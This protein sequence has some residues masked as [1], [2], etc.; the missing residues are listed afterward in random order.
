MNR[1]FQFV[2]VSASTCMLV[3]LL[4]G[5]FLG[6]SRAA[7]D[8]YRQFGVYTEVL[9]KIKSE[10][11]EEPDIKNVTLGAMMG[12][13]ESL[14]PYASYLNADQYK[15]YLRSRENRKGDVGL[16][17]ARRFGYVA[18]VASIPGSPAANAG[19]GTGDLLETIA[20][21]ATRDM[22]LAYADMLL[23]GEPGTKVDISVLRVRRGAE[24]QKMTLVREPVQYPA[25]T[26]QII[27]GDVAYLAVPSLGPGRVG[28]V[29][30]HLR[31][32]TSRGA[33]RIVLDLRHNASG[34]PEDGIALA[35]LFLDKGL[36][37]YLSGQRSPRQDFNADPSKTIAR[38]PLVVLT[39]RGTAGGA[40]VAAAALLDNKR[41]EVVG[42]RTYGDAAVRRALT[43]DDGSAVILSVAKYHSPGGKAIQDNAVTPSVPMVES[44]P[45]FD[46]EEETPEPAPAV[47]PEDD[48]LVKKAIEVFT[49]GARVARGNSADTAEPVR[50]PNPEPLITPLGVPRPK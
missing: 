19:L 2:I 1:R 3:L 37:T 29:E 45:A 48:P 8:A 50:E 15:Q 5:S 21:V 22:P 27:A 7:D 41:A 46:T 18:I 9:Q 30:R 34:A 38:G 28:D 12:L 32:T 44:E 25:V 13:L 6:S 11:V 35:N 33:R 14:D 23:H 26:S 39:N 4:A 20:G 31:E 42:E 16:V 40:E 24:P 17:I 43:L 10:Y 49:T 36:I 47:K